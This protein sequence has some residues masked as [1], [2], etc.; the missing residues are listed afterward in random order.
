MNR[1]LLWLCYKNTP[2]NV[3][4]E[5]HLFA[6]EEEKWRIDGPSLVL[7][8]IRTAGCFKA[9]TSRE[10]HMATGFEMSTWCTKFLVVL[11]ERSH[12]HCLM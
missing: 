11:R 8:T 6:L 7:G 4:Y 10:S 9:C 2:F 5:I 1:P 3:T 12:A